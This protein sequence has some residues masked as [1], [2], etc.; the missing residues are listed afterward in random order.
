MVRLITSCIFLQT[1]AGVIP[2]NTH[3]Q[4]VTVAQVI[5]QSKINFESFVA[6]LRSLRPEERTR[7]SRS[8]KTAK[9]SRMPR[10]EQK[11][12]ECDATAVDSSSADSYKKTPCG[13]VNRYRVYSLCHD[14]P[15]L[16]TTMKVS[17]AQVQR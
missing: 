6:T 15:L 16:S 8:A 1:W 2:L 7:A 17:V 5:T 12:Q 11:V 14:Y 10:K 4:M 3:I 13:S 9:C